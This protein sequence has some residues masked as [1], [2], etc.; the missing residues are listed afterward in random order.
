MFHRLYLHKFQVLCCAAVTDISQG[1]YLHELSLS[2]HP[3]NLS[4][5]DK[6]HWNI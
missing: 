2:V 1:Y 4:E 5:T 3:V 6:V